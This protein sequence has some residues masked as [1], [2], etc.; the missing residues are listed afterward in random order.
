MDILLDLQKDSLIDS[1]VPAQF[2]LRDDG[3]IRIW[4]GSMSQ[5]PTLTSLIIAHPGH[6]TPN[7]T[8]AMANTNQMSMDAATSAAKRFAHR[9]QRPIMLSY[10]TEPLISSDEGTFRELEAAIRHNLD[11]LLTKK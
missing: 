9:Y 2:E 10:P 6:P 7:A 11:I 1:R 8:V 3:A 4:V 5:G